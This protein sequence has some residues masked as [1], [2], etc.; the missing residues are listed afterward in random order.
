MRSACSFALT[1][2]EEEVVVVELYLAS[3]LYS[4]CK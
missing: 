1:L 4:R 3:M 2:T